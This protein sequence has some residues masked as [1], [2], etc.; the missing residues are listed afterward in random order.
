[1]HL[2]LSSKNLVLLNIF[3]GAL[4]LLTGIYIAVNVHSD[5]VLA[6]QPAAEAPRTL[7][8]NNHSELITQIPKAHIFGKAIPSIGNMPTTNLQFKVTGI[9]KI[10]DD[11]TEKSKAY[12]SIAG[13]PSKIYQIGDN[14]PYGVK[15]YDITSNS[16]ILENDGQL[17]KLPLVRQKLEFKER[18]KVLWGA[19]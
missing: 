6:H 16:V 5:W 9:V 19:E 7:K 14:L 13:Q 12:I 11:A 2:V 1:M 17:E 8:V 18:S 3:I 15:L 10:L 4:F